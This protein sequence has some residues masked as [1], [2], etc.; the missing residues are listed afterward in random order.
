MR[1]K[2]TGCGAARS[3]PSLDPPPGVCRP[4]TSTWHALDGAGAE[5]LDQYDRDPERLRPALDVAARP[6]RCPLSLDDVRTLFKSE[7]IARYATIMEETPIR[8]A[9]VKAHA[10]TPSVARPAPV[11]MEF[12][13]HQFTT[14]TSGSRR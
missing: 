4:S 9:R 8:R 2:L 13:P 12:R 3:L 11:C 6:H 1:E 5:H 14:S 7:P 10:W